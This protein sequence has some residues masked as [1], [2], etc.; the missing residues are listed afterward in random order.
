MKFVK[1]RHT[2]TSS[3]CDSCGSINDSKI[4]VELFNNEDK[5][6]E[7]IFFYDDHFG[8][9]NW[10]GEKINI[11]AYILKQLGYKLDFSA[12]LE[13][14]SDAFDFNPGFETFYQED[15]LEVI[16]VHVTYERDFYLIDNQ[17]TAFVDIPKI[18]SFQLNDKNYS[19][20]SQDF[21]FVY[22]KIVKSLSQVGEFNINPDFQYDD[23]LE[24]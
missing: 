15:N 2:N 13:L 21:E 6:A 10:N 4:E 8:K 24:Y 16:S 1:I 12:S 7:A 22:E 23:E 17:K 14:Y 20:E 18:F 11:W 3:H 9:S 19:L 5:F